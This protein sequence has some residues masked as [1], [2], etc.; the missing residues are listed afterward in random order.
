MDELHGITF[1]TFQSF[2]AFIVSRSSGLMTIT[3]L[4]VHIMQHENDVASL[5]VPKV[6]ACIFSV[7]RSHKPVNARQD[8]R[9]NDTNSVQCHT[10][11]ASRLKMGA[12]L[13]MICK[14]LPTQHRDPAALD[15]VES[16]CP[17]SGP[18]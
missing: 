8:A 18:G 4:P 6:Q 7:L 10:Q 12:P 14:V 9:P 17:T 13:T 15:H 1:G 3:L 5:S 2:L 11:Q 16:E